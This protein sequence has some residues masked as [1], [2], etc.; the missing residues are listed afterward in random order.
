LV[1]VDP[2]RGVVGTK[3]VYRFDTRLLALVA[4]CVEH[5]S[6]VIDLFP[7]RDRA[8]LLHRIQIPVGEANLS[9]E[10]GKRGR[11]ADAAGNGH[12]REVGQT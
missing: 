10:S 8:P 6:G 11:L 3:T 7:P 1:A 5:L 12:N 4:R 9:F 2:V